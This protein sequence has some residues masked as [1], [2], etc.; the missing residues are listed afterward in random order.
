LLL[1]LTNILKSITKKKK[2]KKKKRPKKKKKKKKGAQKFSIV[3]YFIKHRKKVSLII[4]KRQYSF[5][6]GKDMKGQ[7]FKF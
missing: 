6:Y 1:D 5:I 3:E 4:S 7:N 2:K